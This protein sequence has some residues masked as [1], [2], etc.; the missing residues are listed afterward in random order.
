MVGFI[1]PDAGG[2]HAVSSFAPS[3]AF[4]LDAPSGRL[5]V[6]SGRWR[7]SAVCQL[8]ASVRAPP[9]LAY[10]HPS[11]AQSQ[12]HREPARGGYARV[13]E[14]KRAQP[15]A[16]RSTAEVHAKPAW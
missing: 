7:L 12:S 3:A 10:N 16:A 8:P 14:R 11:L 13:S 15:K 1:Q 6:V 9:S 2:L 4:W 5:E